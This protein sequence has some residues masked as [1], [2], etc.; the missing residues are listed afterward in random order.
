M[1]LNTGLSIEIEP[2]A[3]QWLCLFA[4]AQTGRDEAQSIWTTQ[5][6]KDAKKTRPSIFLG[7]LASWRGLLEASLVQDRCADLSIPP[8]QGSND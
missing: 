5:R 6:R 7:V 4:P 2:G 1:I 3:P 8:L